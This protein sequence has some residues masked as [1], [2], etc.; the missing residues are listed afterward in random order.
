MKKILTMKLN[1]VFLISTMLLLFGCASNHD[2]DSMGKATGK[3]ITKAAKA[4]SSSEIYEVH[5]DGRIYVFYDRNLFKEF[6]ALGETPFRLTRIGA[7]PNGETLVFGLTKHDKKNPGKV[8][9]INYYDHRI[10]APEHIYAE[11]HR[12]GRIYVFDKFEEMKP[13]R[14][15]GHPNLFY[16]EIGAGPKGETVVFV[17]NEE[18]KKKRPDALIDKFKSMNL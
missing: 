9:V 3:T 17:L 10:Q 1:T 4:I 18:N 5:Q 12:H 8:N 13:V 7:G 2:N 14:Q 15:F 16:T 6:V 11:M